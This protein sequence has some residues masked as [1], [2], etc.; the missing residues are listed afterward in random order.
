MLLD[1]FSSLDFCFSNL[2]ILNSLGFSWFAV[3]FVFLSLFSSFFFSFHLVMV[4]GFFNMAWIEKKNGCLVFFTI[5]SVVFCLIFFQNVLGLFPFTFSITSHIVFN[6]ILALEI[7]FSIIFFGF[8]NNLLGLLSHFSPFGSPLI[9]SNF[10]NLIEVVSVFIRSLTLS[11]RLSVNISTG[12]IFLGL[13]S[14]WLL[15]SSFN[16]VWWISFI[17][18]VGYFFFELFVSFIQALVFSLLLV[19]YMD[20]V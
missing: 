8:L 12:H 14:S 1:I 4:G 11:L 18:F 19:Q 2:S 5:L 17:C 16:I 13:V 15:I 9:L 10:L 6:F 3:I 20:E 7:W